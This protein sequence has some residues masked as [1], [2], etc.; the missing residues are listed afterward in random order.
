MS[1]GSQMVK[2]KKKKKRR[3]EMC[4]VNLSS[5][6]AWQLKDHSDPGLTLNSQVVTALGRTWHPEHFICGGCSMSLGG[7]SFFEKDGAPFCPECYFERFSPRCGL[8]NQPIRH[9]SCTCPTN[10][11]SPGSLWGGP[12]SNHSPPPTHAKPLG[13]VQGPL[14]STH[15]L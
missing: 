4:H 12:H 1:E 14:D 8:C 15:S 3:L 7:S 13:C 2:R 11:T 5:L 9:V 10:P 6:G